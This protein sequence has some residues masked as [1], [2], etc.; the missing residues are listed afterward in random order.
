MFHVYI[1]TIASVLLAIVL[2]RPPSMVFAIISFIIALI[3]LIAI[4]VRNE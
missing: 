4:W 3:M 1:V 2:L